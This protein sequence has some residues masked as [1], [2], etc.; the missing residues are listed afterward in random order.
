MLSKYQLPIKKIEKNIKWK[1][2]KIN[3]NEVASSLYKA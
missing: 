3:D 1:R 2:K